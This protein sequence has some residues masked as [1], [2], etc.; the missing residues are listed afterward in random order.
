MILPNDFV[1]VKNIKT[2]FLGWILSYYGP[3]VLLGPESVVS[4]SDGPFEMAW[5]LSPSP[6]KHLRLSLSARDTNVRAQK[7]AVDRDDAVE[8]LFEENP[9][10]KPRTSVLSSGKK[11]SQVAIRSLLGQY[12]RQRGNR[13]LTFFPMTLTLTLSTA[14]LLK[15]EAKVMSSTCTVV[16]YA[17]S[18]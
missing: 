12:R 3:S 7:I 14:V 16:P 10:S 17:S 1:Q 2:R 18:R 5:T 4:L 15:E 9:E 13:S 11:Q 8:G 6:W